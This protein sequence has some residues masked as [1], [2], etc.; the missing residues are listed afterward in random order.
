MGKIG[1][2]VIGASI[3]GWTSLSHVPALRA[4]PDFELRAISTSR[5]ESADAAAREFGVE[6]AFDDHRALLAHPGV[7][8]VVV[9]VK[10][11]HHHELVSDAIAAGKTVYSEWPLA[12]DLAEAEDLVERARTAGVRTAVGLQGRYAPEIARAR[13][14]VRDGHIGR[15]LGTV[16]VGSGMVWGPE[17]VRSKAYWYDRASGSTLLEGAVVHAVDALTTTLGEFARFSANLVVGRDVVS[18][19]DEGVVVPVTAPDQ[20]SLIGTLDSGAAASVTYRGG[21]SRGD[22]FRWEINGTDGDL[23]LTADWGN[24]QVADLTLAI[25]RGGD[26][27]VTPVDLPPTGLTGPARNVAALYTHLAADLRDGTHTV[28]DFEYALSRHRLVADVVRS[29][30]T[31]ARA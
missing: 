16:L 7:D 19:A 24:V 31:G 30:Q 22:N 29:S 26:T 21:T 27:T 13:E 2:G 15:V 11:A 20:V 6:A 25:G 3:G 17:T 12:V 9:A 18:I 5:R 28:P 4:S 14:L 23:V 10:V 8:V 1:V